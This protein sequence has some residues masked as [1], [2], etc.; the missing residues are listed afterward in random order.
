MLKYIF[1]FNPTQDT[2]IDLDPDVHLNDW[3]LLS[4]INLS[5][6]D[7]CSIEIIIQNTR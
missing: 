7:T 5:L 2:Q 1:Y 3:S 6:M 4:L